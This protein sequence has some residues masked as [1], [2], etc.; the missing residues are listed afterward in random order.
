MRFL[1]LQLHNFMCFEDETLKLDGQGLV[2]VQGINKDSEAANGN[3]SG[4]SSLIV[5]GLL[6]TLFGKTAR[7]IKGDDVVRKGADGCLA[8]V[9]WEQDKTQYRVVRH[10]DHPEFGN[11]LGFTCI[12]EQTDTTE[13]T[14]LTCTDKRRTQEL[15]EKTLSFGMQLAL[16]A[17]V[18]GQ[19]SLSFVG[20]TD[21]VK[22][23]ILETI[24]QFE[25][26]NDAQALAKVKAATLQD[27]ITE[28]DKDLVKAQTKQ[29]SLT[30]ELSRLD[31]EQTSWQTRQEALTQQLREQLKELQ[32]RQGLQETFI[33]ER[34]VVRERL[35]KFE[36]SDKER[37]ELT[38]V[39]SAMRSQQDI[40]L[41]KV[42]LTNA[43]IVRLEVSTKAKPNPN[44]PR[45][46]QILPSSE[47]EKEKRRL[48]IERKDLRGYLN[49]VEQTE[50]LVRL[51]KL[52]AEV[53]GVALNELP[54]LEKTQ[55]DR[56]AYDRLS[57][58][59][60]DLL[61]LKIERHEEEICKLSSAVSP[62]AGLIEK[63]VQNLKEVDQ[64]D[65]Q[66]VKEVT[67]L[68]SEKAYYD[69][70][71]V[72]FGKKGLQSYLLDA[73]VPFLT[74]RANVYAATLCGG[75]VSIEFKTTIETEDGTPRDDLVVNCTNQ[76]GADKY[77]G[78]SGGE[79]N[80][81]DMAVTLAL[82]DLVLSRLGTDMNFSVF[83][84]STPFTDTE[85]VQRVVRL[86]R[87]LSA[88][89]SSIFF[90]SHNP[91]YLDHFDNHLTVVKEGGIS[92]L[93][94]TA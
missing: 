65:K 52:R 58:R 69:F 1:E 70:W 35:T 28:T 59:I 55:A 68:K 57:S 12:Q 40:L 92:R 83:D 42:D 11:S 36:D 56:Q 13:L 79:Q 6:W 23:Q 60:D 21:A 45:C 3:G 25:F 87:E 75:D 81:I 22:K 66:L 88:T 78:Q 15:I 14:N 19:K 63:V 20:A 27:K 4:K 5:E 49:E 89:R 46:G 61:T 90:V 86:L 77:E 74:E 2:F 10:Q 48:A 73:A 80:R 17:L 41:S 16:Y 72:G 62:Y 93:E 47:L 26:L 24:M 34:D 82:Q 67:S 44:C 71:I 31:T 32:R 94:R 91:D 29:T 43:A 76:C 18:L 7:G 53:A 9:H 84:E 8:S 50:T 64:Q 54:A 30:A 37:A 39:C 85:G 38:A 33:Q 51:C